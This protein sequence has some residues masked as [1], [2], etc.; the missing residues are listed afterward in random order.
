MILLIGL[1]EVAS[2]DCLSAG[3]VKKQCGDLK[4]S[5]MHTMQVDFMLTAAAI[6]LSMKQTASAF[7]Q[8][9]QITM[10][11]RLLSALS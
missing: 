5:E 3:S 2:Q 10:A 1:L 7:L 4:E 6:A 9:F 8:T 11:A